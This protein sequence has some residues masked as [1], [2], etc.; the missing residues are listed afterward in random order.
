MAEVLKFEVSKD[1]LRI[2]DA[3]GDAAER[4]IFKMLETAIAVVVESWPAQKELASKHT[5]AEMENRRKL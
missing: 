1:I 5:I 3:P 4:C 2:E